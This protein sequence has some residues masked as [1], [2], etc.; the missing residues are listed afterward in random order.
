MAEA[1][2]RCGH[3]SRPEVDA[4]YNPQPNGL[5]SLWSMAA[6]R[7]GK[8]VLC[9]KPFAANG[10]EARAVADM[11]SGGGK[12]VFEAFDHRYHPGR[13]SLS[14]WCSTRVRAT[15]G[16]RSSPTCSVC[17]PLYQRPHRVT[18]CSPGSFP[19]SAWRRNAPG[20]WNSSSRRLQSPDLSG[21]LRPV[22]EHLL[23]RPGRL[24]VAAIIPRR[25]N[26]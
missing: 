26:L 6:I 13:R 2:P 18:P 10:Q 12:V 23:P 9:E 4:I 21:I 17:H 14:R 24:Q 8:H 22:R 3:G 7:A 1:R 19:A 15:C 25:T 20:T 5:H 16:V 11:A